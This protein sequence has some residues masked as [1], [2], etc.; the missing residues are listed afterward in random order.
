[1]IDNLPFPDDDAIALG[2]SLL[3]RRPLF[4]PHSSKDV[5]SKDLRDL[6]AAAD[7]HLVR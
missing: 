5:V 6:I 3:A 1:M 7:A 4:A 2:V